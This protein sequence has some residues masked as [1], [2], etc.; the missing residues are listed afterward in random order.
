MKKII[1]ASLVLIATCAT[2]NA[3]SS[4]TDSRQSELLKITGPEKYSLS[5]EELKDLILKKPADDQSVGGVREKKRM[6]T[7][8]VT[9]TDSPQVEPLKF[10]PTD[11]YS[12]SLEELKALILQKPANDKSV[13]GVREKQ[14]MQT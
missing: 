3:A 7:L 1:V 14:R 4:T 2:V 8:Q 12:L 5:L 6:L 13:G 9:P 10:K 11:G